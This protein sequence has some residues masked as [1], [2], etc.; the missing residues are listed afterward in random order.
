MAQKG[1]AMRKLVSSVLRLLVVL[2]VACS[3]D[4]LPIADGV[5]DSGSDAAVALDLSEIL[6][7]APPSDFA[8][9][10]DC[11][12]LKPGDIFR[13]EKYP[14]FYIIN[15]A[16]EYMYFPLETEGKWKQ[17]IYFIWRDVSDPVCGLSQ[18]RFDAMPA[19]RKLP[20]GINYRPGTYLVKRA[21]TQQVYAVLPG[22][23]RAKITPEVA[24]VLYAPYDT[25]AGVGSE[26]VVVPDVYWPNLVNT[27]PDITEARVHPGMLF[28]YKDEAL[29]VYYMDQNSVI[30][31][32]Y[33]D[34]ISL[35]HFRGIFLRSVPRSATEGFTF[36]PNMNGL[37]PF[38]NDP[39]QG[40]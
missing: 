23:T 22:N 7:F 15:S 34:A 14:T 3:S 29:V 30:H 6:D 11:G 33:R 31:M 21:G 25:V 13:V 10:P 19:P 9:L 5:V 4:P 39:T 32:M 17:D 20:L 2:L 1:S 24:A 35:N 12:T 18:A 8:V 27:A 38:I 16:G 37:D 28:K 40:G 26:P 36:G